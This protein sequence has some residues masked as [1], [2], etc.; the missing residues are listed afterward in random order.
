M[1]KIGAQFHIFQE[2]VSF[3]LPSSR[4][5][6]MCKV[7]IS[8]SLSLSL[9]LSI[10]FVEVWISFITD[11]RDTPFANETFRKNNNDDSDSMLCNNNS[12]RMMPR[13][14]SR[15]MRRNG[16]KGGRKKKK[17][18]TVAVRKRKVRVRQHAFWRARYTC[19]RVFFF[20]VYKFLK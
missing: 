9:S 8:L 10:L 11:R 15:E 18:D 5:L 19:S 12:M 1:T 20:F 14:F 2:P 6:L 7:G 17:D 16:R 4:W 3:W 13:D